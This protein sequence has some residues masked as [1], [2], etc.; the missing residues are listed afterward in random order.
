LAIKFIAQI[1]F[2][3]LDVSTFRGISI[4]LRDAEIGIKVGSGIG[5]IG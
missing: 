4:G 5:V 3:N 1:F 2:K